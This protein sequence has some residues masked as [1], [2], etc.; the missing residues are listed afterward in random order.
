MQIFLSSAMNVLRK[1]CLQEEN[2]EFLFAALDVHTY[3]A[4]VAVLILNDV[5]VLR[6]YVYLQYYGQCF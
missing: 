2:V 1:V 5:Q 6:H 4:L 3:E